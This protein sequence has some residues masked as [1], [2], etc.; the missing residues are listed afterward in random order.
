[1]MGSPHFLQVALFLDQLVIGNAVTRSAIVADDSH[2][3][4]TLRQKAY[5]WTGTSLRSLF[6]IGLAPS[7]FLLEPR[8]KAHS[9]SIVKV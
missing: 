8:P 6:R 5:F 2:S 4:F 1:M 9:V 3:S 7:Q